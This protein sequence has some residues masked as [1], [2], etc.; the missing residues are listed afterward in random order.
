MCVSSQ[1]HTHLSAFVTW[2]TCSIHFSQSL[3]VARGMASR[4]AASASHS[5][6][7][8]FLITMAGL[9]AA[10]HCGTRH[11]RELLCY[12]E[13]RSHTQVN[14]TWTPPCG[15]PL[16]TRFFILIKLP[17]SLA[18]PWFFILLPLI[19]LNYA[20]LMNNSDTYYSLSVFWLGS[21]IFGGI[22]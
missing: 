5:V 7:A 8:R 14:E 2:S 15:S 11:C 17:L 20:Y 21:G 22:I 9:P 12:T 13:A 19:V 16:S 6:E 1:D 10:I 18:T 3:Q 4:T